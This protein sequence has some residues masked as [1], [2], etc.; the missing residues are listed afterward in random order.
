MRNAIPLH[1][2][3][4]AVVEIALVDQRLNVL[5]SL[6]RQ[7]IEQLERHLSIADFGAIGHVEHQAL[8]RAGLNCRLQQA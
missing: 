8:I 5:R 3:A 6:R 4:S 7:I 2:Q 1:G